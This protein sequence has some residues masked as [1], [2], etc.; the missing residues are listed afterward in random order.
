LAG[1]KAHQALRQRNL[2]QVSL[3]QCQ[4]FTRQGSQ[5]PIAPS[6]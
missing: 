4:G 5:E 1:L 3:K 6:T 2:L